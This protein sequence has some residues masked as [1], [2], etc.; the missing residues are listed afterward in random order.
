MLCGAILGLVK[1]HGVSSIP[2]SSSIGFVI[3]KNTDCLPLLRL[4]PPGINPFL[5]MHVTCSRRGT[6]TQSVLLV[7]VHSLATQDQVHSLLNVLELLEGTGSGWKSL[8]P[9]NIENFSWLLLLL[10]AWISNR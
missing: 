7:T 1:S 2:L 6:C 4:R 9:S 3:V 8:D 5:I 10:P